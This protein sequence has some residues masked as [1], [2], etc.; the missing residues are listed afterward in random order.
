MKNIDKQ[1]AESKRE[2]V[3]D[4]STGGARKVKN[5]STVEVAFGG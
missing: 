2:A 1:R 4:D 5:C 3:D